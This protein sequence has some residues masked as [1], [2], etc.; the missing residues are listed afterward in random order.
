MTADRLEI[1]GQRERELV[2]NRLYLLHAPGL[3]GNQV[4]NSEAITDAGSLASPVSATYSDVA[5]TVTDC[6]HSDQSRQMEE[7]YW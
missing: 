6:C 7:H 2:L 1:F 3:N 4:V 5:V